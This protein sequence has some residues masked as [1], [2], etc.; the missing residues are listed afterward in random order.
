MI[1]LKEIKTALSLFILMVIITGF[2][3]PMLITGVANLLFQDKASGSLIEKNSK[4]IG[5]KL[6]G[7]NFTSEKYFHPRPSSA[8]Y[9]AT[10]SGG[11]NLSQT[12]KELK[13]QIATRYKKLANEQPETKIPA[14]LLTTSASGL[15]PHISPEAAIFQVARVAKARNI[16]EAIILKIIERNTEGRSLGIFGE[17]RVNV[18][19]LNLELDR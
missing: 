6:I 5:S 9:N 17:P 3:Y 2:S 18:L 7:Q 1:M 10:N 15:D 4:I 16:D 12:S 11:S 14:D 13:E 8:E 19:L